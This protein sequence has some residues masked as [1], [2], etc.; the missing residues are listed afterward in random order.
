MSINIAKCS[1][2]AAKMYEWM[3]SLVE[4]YTIFPGNLNIRG[5]IYYLSILASSM[6]IILPFTRSNK[7]LLSI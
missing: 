2:Q 7:D 4:E 1:L 6:Q 3:V 5:M